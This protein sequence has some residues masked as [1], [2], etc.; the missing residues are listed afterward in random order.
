M[1]RNAG[2]DGED[3]V[4]FPAARH[5]GHGRG[6]VPRRQGAERFVWVE[7]QG[8]GVFAQGRVGVGGKGQRGELVIG[9]VGHAA[10]VASRRSVHHAGLVHHVGRP[11]RSRHHVGHEEPFRPGGGVPP[12]LSVRRTTNNRSPWYGRVNSGRT[13]SIRLDAYGA[14]GWLAGKACPGP[15]AGG[16]GRPG[17][18]PVGP[19]RA[20]VTGVVARRGRCSPS[21]ASWAW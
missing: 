16:G 14:V 9:Y 7:R 1:T 6:H 3:G 17:P 20:P 15:G 5:P 18:G 4:P 8:D 11:Q 21:W 13:R 12:P 2:D 10:V 19:D